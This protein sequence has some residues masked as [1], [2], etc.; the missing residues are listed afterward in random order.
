MTEMVHGAIPAAAGEPILP[1]WWRTID[2]WSLGCVLLLF[3]IGMLLGLA[4]SPPLAERNGLDP[5][6]YVE[7][8]AAFGVLALIVLVAIVDDGAGAGA[9]AGADRVRAHARL[10]R[11]PAVLRHRLRQGRGALVLAAASARVQPSEFLKPCFVVVCAWFMAAS[12]ELNGP[13][14]KIYSAILAVVV[15]AFLVHPARFRAGGA[16]PLRLGR[17]VFRGRR[18]GLPSRGRRGRGRGGGHA[19]LRKLG[20]TSPAGSTASCPPRSIRARRSASPPTRSARAASSAWA[21]AR[22]R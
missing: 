2:R 5:F 17:D 3:G 18:A 14:G 20:R 19:R 11:L 21:W 13:P 9:A 8:Q 22:G 16:D 10:A 12:D 7:R 6:Y 4:A 1:R 15:A